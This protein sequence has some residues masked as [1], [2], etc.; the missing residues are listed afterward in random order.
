MEN[1]PQNL[2]DMDT[3]ARLA[4]Y[5][6]ELR[7]LQMGQ[8]SWLQAISHDLRAPLRHLLSF[9][10]LVSELLEQP[11]PSTQDLAEARGF[12]LTM[13][14]SAKRLAAM[15]DALL[16]L[17]RLAITPLQ[18]RSVDLLELL[19]NAKAAVLARPQW[20][21]LSSTKPP[22]WSWPAQG[23][24]LLADAQL[25]QQTL[26][27]LLDNAIKFSQHREQPHIEISVESE[28]DGDIA[29]SIRDN[30]AGFEPARADAL[31][32][33]FQRM[34]R[35]AEFP[36]LGTGLAMVQSVMRRHGG[37]ASISAHPDQGCN[38]RLYWPA[39]AFICNEA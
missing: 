24:T 9:G 10:P 5:E 33:I 25:L 15:L 7:A 1:S 23:A 30:G 34:H 4:K 6:R 21:G 27:E 20:A 3:L 19:E 11:T 22:R 14:Q 16:R 32:G 26:E 13:D 12:L 37:Q 38:V 17:S 31:F 2:P 29:L 28:S 8:Q 39:P 36:G 35:E 18:T